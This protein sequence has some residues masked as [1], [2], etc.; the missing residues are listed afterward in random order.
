MMR[1]L[2]YPVVALCLA[3]AVTESLPAFGW[4]CEH[5]TVYRWMLYGMAAYLIIRLLPF[6][7]RNE[8]WLQTFSHEMTHA[9]VGLM[10]FQKIH[11]FHA[12]ENQ[13]VVWRSG[14]PIG[15][16]FIGL[17]PYCLPIYTY[18][19]LLLRIMSANKMLY[20]F[21]LLIGFSLAFHI[22]CFLKQTRLQQPDIKDR[23]Y[24]RSFL[25]IATALLF[26]A[27]IILLSVRKGIV[28]AVTYLFPRYWNDI[29][30]WWNLIV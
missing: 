24:L 18:A 22:V 16:M 21:D 19:F 13:G 20:I 27:T 11:S 5:I 9:V 14:R 1:F 2:Y 10:F 17:A 7:S 29:V 28:G 25:F 8:P 12:E 6:I 30:T 15:D 4:T 23:G 3:L 26:N